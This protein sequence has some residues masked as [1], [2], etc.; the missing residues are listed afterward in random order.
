[1]QQPVVSVIVPIYKV[2]SYLHRCVDSILNQTFTAFE[3]ILVD[4]GSPDNCPEI[5]D[6]YTEKDNRVHVIHLDN[7]GPSVARNAGIDWAF[8][9]SDS[10]WICFIDGDDWVHHCYLEVLI[11]QAK[12]YL[13]DI[14]MCGFLKKDCYCMDHLLSGD[15]SQMLSPEEAYVDFY[16]ICM[17]PW[18]KIYRK[19]LFANLRFP[20]G[21]IHEDAFITHLL[22]FSA[23]KIA[24]S[25]E[26]LYYYY[27]NPNSITRSKWSPKRLTEI[28]AHEQRLLFFK[29]K[30]FPNAYKREVKAYLYA[31]YNQVQALN[32]VD[33][34]I[35][36]KRQLSK[37]LRK[38]LVKN[39]RMGLF[40][41]KS[42][43]H[44]Y[45]TAFPMAMKFYWYFQALLRKLYI[46]K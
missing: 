34:Y 23:S 24:V 37:K 38:V 17:S 25:D 40:E 42:N 22:T 36:Y 19:N 45:E 26:F 1:M 13:A 14:S 30:N 29:D 18:S 28:E 5:C 44:I 43:A 2:D 35:K 41:L 12:R 15:S 21:K 46:R 8:A 16:G 20:V 7:G 32:C 6:E 10:E 31:L 3:L 39:C 27:H 9:N 33:E 4:D 11:T